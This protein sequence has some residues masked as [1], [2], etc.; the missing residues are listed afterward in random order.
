MRTLTTL[1]L[2]ILLS[3]S[4]P[5][6]EPQGDNTA[7][8]DP[9]GANLQLP[10]LILKSWPPA[11]PAFLYAAKARAEVQVNSRTIEQTIQ[12]DIRV[13]QGKGETVSLGLSGPG[14]VVD[15]QGDGIVSWA[16]RTVGA[17]RFLDVIVKSDGNDRTATIKL[18]AE[19][20]KVPAQVDL[21]HL[22]NGKAL[23]F[24][25]QITIQYS[26]GVA[27]KVV[28]ATGFAPLISTSKTTRL[29]SA[30]GGRLTL[31]LDRQSSLPPAIELQNTTLEGLA[32]ATGESVAFKLNGTA[33]VNEVNSKL[34]VLAGNIALSKLPES[35]DY[36]LELLV[37][38]SGPVYELT[39]AKLGKFSVDLEFVAAIKAPSANLRSIEFTVA[40]GAI[41]PLK[42][43]GI[44]PEVSFSSENQAVVLMPIDGVWQGFL[45]ASGKVHLR[46]QD[47]KEEG[48]ERKLFFTTASIVDTRVG[49]GLLSQEH[50]INY[51][52]LQGQIRT[53]TIAMRG[54]GEIVSVEGD[55]IV[56]WKVVGEGVERT[57]EVTLNQLISGSSQLIVRSQ[58]PLSEFPVR[59]D[60][61]TLQPQGA[62]RSSGHLRI[63]SYG[64]ARVEPVGL[65]GLSQLAPEQFPGGAITS[66]QLFVYRFPSADY[67]FSIAADRVEPEVNVT[68]LL[69]YQIGE[70]DRIIAADIELDVREAAIREWNVKVPADYSVVSVVGNTV[71][72]YLVAADAAE[73]AR[74]LKVLFNQDL[75][76]RQLINLR[77]EKNE[78]AV[79]GAWTLPKLQFTGAKTI[80]GDVG[81]IA[82]AGFRASLAK[83]DLLVEKPLSYF[84]KSIANLQQAF[85]IR[86]PEWSATIQIDPIERSVQSDMFHLYSLSQGTVFGSALVNY[87]VTGAPVSQWRLQVPASLENVAVDGPEIRTWRREGDVLVVSLQRPVMGSYTLLVTFEDKPSGTDGSFQAGLVAPIDVQSDRGYIEVVSPIQVEMES[88][89]VSNQLLVLDPL[90]L[91]AE[92]RLLSTAPALGTWQYTQRPFQLRLKVNWF[93][94][95]TTAAQ[96]VEFSEANSRVSQDGEQVTDLLYYVKS[97]GQRTLKL[98]LPGEPVRLWAVTVAG[99]PV[100][101]RQAGE[102]TLIPLPGEADPNT[103]IEVSLRLGKAAESK[104]RA[105]LQLPVVFA[106]VLKT[107]WNILA[108]Q[109]HTL[110]PAGGTVEP[111]IPTRWPNGFDWLGNKG[112]VGLVALT[113]FVLATVL[114]RWAPLRIALSMMTLFTAV[115]FAVD[116]REGIIRDEPIQLNLP[117]MASGEV[118]NMDVS[119]IPSWR[120][121]ISWPGI[122]AI[123]VGSVL[124]A[125]YFGKAKRGLMIATGLALVSI[126]LLL[127]TNGAVGFWCFAILSILL[128]Q[129]LPIG[130]DFYRMVQEENSKSNSKNTLTDEQTMNAANPKNGSGSNGESNSGGSD[131]GGPTGGSVVTSMLVFCLLTFFLSS[132]CLARA[133]EI[134]PAIQVD[135]A[136]A[137]KAQA[138]NAELA[139]L[140][141]AS[142]MVQKWNLSTRENRLTASATITLSGREGDRFAV[143]RSPAVLTKFEGEG[144]RLSKLDLPN[145][146]TLYV[147]TIPSQDGKLDGKSPDNAGGDE[148]IAPAAAPANEEANEKT[149]SKQYVATFEYQLD[150]VQ[151]ADGIAVLTGG[152]ALQQIELDYDAENLEIICEAAARIEISKQPKNSAKILLGAQP[153]KVIVRPKSRDLTTEATQFFVETSGLYTPGP[154]VVDGKHRFKIRTSQGKVKQL[155]ISIPAGFT[156]SSVEGSVANWQ[157]DAEK[158][159]LRT[160]IDPAAPSE[161]SI[162]VETQSS[163]AALPTKIE[164]S[165]L[166]IEGAGSEIGLLAL[167]FGSEAQPE[168]VQAESLSQVSL[169]DFDSSL[170][171]NNQV[172]IHQVFRYGG[173]GGEKGAAQGVKLSLQVSPVAPEI[174]VATKQV[175]SLGDERVVLAINLMAEITRTGVFQLSFPLPQGFEIESISGEALHHWSELAE[176]GKR[177][178][179]L[180]L[181]GKTL[182]THKFALTLASA[183]PSGVATQAEAN[184]WDLPRFELNDASRQSGD[185]V[186]QPITGLRLRATGRQ[187]ISEIDPRTMGAQ[188]QG[189][190][191][192]RLLQR[193]WSLQLGIERLS[194][195]VTGQVLHDVTLR[196][197][198]TRSTLMAELNVQNA[199][200][201]SMQVKLPVSSA[202]VIKT[203]RAHGE[204]VGD[205][206]RLGDEGNVWEL[207]FKRRVI[208]PLRFQIEFERRGDRSGNSE[209]LD[210]VEFPDVQQVGYYFA[211]RAGGRLEVESG[212]LSQGW[213]ASDWSSIPQ[214]LR[215]AGRRTAPAIA[216]RASSPTT[217]LTLRVIRHSLAESLKLRVAAGTLTTVL[218]QTGD[219]L[220]S[221]DVTLEVIQRS[222]LSLQLPKGGELLSIFVNGES[223]HTTHQKGNQDVWQFYVLPGIDD[224]TAQ[225]RFTYSLTGDGLPRLNLASPQLN[226]PLENIQW[227]VLA[228]QGYDLTSND[229]S[230]EL[231]GKQN[232]SNYDRKSYLG[233]LVGNRQNDAQQA[234]RVLAQANE[235]LQSGQRSKA[236]WALNNV[237][238]R[239]ALDAASNEDARVQLENLQLQQAVVGLNTR[240]QRLLLDGNRDAAVAENDQLRQAAAANPILLQEQ[241]NYRPQDLGQLLAGNTKEDNAVLQQIAG[242]LVLHQRT[243]DPAPQAIIISLPEEGNMYSFRRAVQVAENAPLELKLQ[244]HS[245][246]KLRTWQWLVLGSLLVVIAIGLGARASR[247]HRSVGGDPA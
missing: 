46:W 14:E 112:M 70:T 48:V 75:L 221:V 199:A 238:N 152:A 26:D 146:S 247:P 33:V 222:S 115:I 91:P 99:K 171:T 34:R 53:F 228:P 244:F 121:F 37:T 161:F 190:L 129:L 178:I 45:P 195:W 233:S 203:V 97:R 10:A 38:D 100:T 98:R 92:F 139:S 60:A 192:F 81:V 196:E 240:R 125:L 49:P 93:E 197:G 232:L 237:A 158:S 51:Q 118:V 149:P 64:S 4:C 5:A 103:P 90:E 229:G 74:N 89:Q 36:R 124:L 211:V 66:R 80:R 226:V 68:H 204:V 141:T 40:A 191:A 142:A 111:A 104:S 84:P 6:Q 78:A 77:L 88:S 206:V 63:S 183:A 127:Q 123:V 163:L 55:N 182:G 73:G 2:M 7:P 239:Y 15:V 202:D 243:A 148:A 227:K 32:D 114:V 28:E 39:F 72:D 174:R 168:N 181:N 23:G 31:Q 236:Q 128:L 246:Y 16:V 133:D 65:R 50:R 167:A 27:G 210:P 8:Q 213:Q 83:S 187:N 225:V 241:S 164:L 79:A 110:I 94:P 57:L 223:V 116:A 82:A 175:L 59:V 61:L 101:A 43:Q 106:P 135:E 220:T 140:R 186:V 207:R 120:A 42:L 25:S 18:R 234:A 157:F 144:L 56:G 21:A 245:N 132:D 87:T 155:N 30:S 198:Q 217:P 71:S 20:Q 185:L 184:T 160:R 3:W 108:D 105:S 131:S 219:Q 172:T 58:T 194:P 95:G 156:V 235:L 47:S 214:T 208:G 1:W 119:N 126:G 147:I 218:S 150:G 201:R 136:V 138:T 159:Q 35:A 166:T 130:I 151:P 200:I 9:L 173:Q 137:Q 85:R 22:T 13:V 29:Q 109:N 52:L 107:Q 215:E 180:H 153:A 19:I 143:L 86:Q 212:P 17:Q 54:P 69:M 102:D 189:A 231:V 62:I 224:R 134:S 67:A 162:V 176:N 179:I 12:L 165:P 122:G 44:A 242:R 170:N 41:V 24:D 193:D 76:G 96:V 154:G 230:L 177:Q 117:V 113:I 205:F 145:Q 169:G 209:Q 188:G 216:V 11:P